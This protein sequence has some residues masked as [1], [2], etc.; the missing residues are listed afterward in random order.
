MYAING[1]RQ[2]FMNREGLD[3]EFVDDEPRPWPR[4]EG[5]K[6]EYSGE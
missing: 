4:Y 5:S 3:Y 1:S 2:E 6:V